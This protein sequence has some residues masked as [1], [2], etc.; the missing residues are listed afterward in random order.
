MNKLVY[1]RNGKHYRKLER[2]ETI[3]EGALQS[4]CHGEFQPI[5]NS[6]GETVGGKPSD[7]SDERDFYNPTEL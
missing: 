6:D 7:F 5:M 1:F 4:W 3:E 2:H